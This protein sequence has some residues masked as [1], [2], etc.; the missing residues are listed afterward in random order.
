MLNANAE[1][2][3][4]SRT[5]APGMPGS[6][7]ACLD[8]KMR[9]ALRLH[10]YLVASHWNGRALNVPDVGFRFNSRIGRFI[11]SYLPR[12][13]WKDNYYYVQAQGYWIL[14]NWHLYSSTRDNRY[15]DIAL[16]CSEFLLGRQQE[17][18]A[19]LHPNPEWRGPNPTPQVSWG[20]L[21]L[22]QGPPPTAARKVL[23]LV[24]RRNR[25]RLM[26]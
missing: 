10:D 20:S 1:K 18:G 5:N 9:A 11:K 24:R 25:D 16:R 12:V 23:N 26:P 13:D 8:C 3:V 22:L 15:R 7:V 17:D 14:D 2:N 6:E 21:G 4:A 19:W